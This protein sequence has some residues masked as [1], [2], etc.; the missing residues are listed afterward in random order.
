MK[1]HRGEDLKEAPPS[2]PVKIL[3][4]KAVP[5]VGDFLQVV[6]DTKELKKKV[7]DLQHQ[8]KAYRDRKAIQKSKSKNEDEDDEKQSIDIILKT[9]TIGSQEAIVQSLETISTDDVEIRIAKKGLGNITDA[10]VL[11]ADATGAFLYGFN[12][13][14][15]A[16]ANEIAK[17]KKQEV[18]TFEV[19]YDLT[20]AVKKERE[21]YKKVEIE[22]VDLGRVKVLA[23]FK[24]GKKNMIIGGMITKGKIEVD[25]RAIIIRDDKPQAEGIISKLQQAKQDVKTIASGTE[26]GIEFTGAPI[27]KEGD[28]LDVYKEEIKT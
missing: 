25:A 8:R 13:K 17:E 4:L 22:R 6:E 27:I 10:D 2:T 18:E 28:F 14:V 3:G 9:D 23:I 11:Q 12:V 5:E 24:T 16:G 21:K 1:N 19:I 15:N 26:C 7:R 20:D